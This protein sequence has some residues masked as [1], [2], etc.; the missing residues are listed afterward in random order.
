M[1]KDKTEKE[2]KA[3]CIDQLDVFLQK[4]N[5]PPNSLYMPLLCIYAYILGMCDLVGIKP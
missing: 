4:G 5:L 1:K 3:L 2:L